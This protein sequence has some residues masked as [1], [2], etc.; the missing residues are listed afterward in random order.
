MR[1]CLK[2]PVT[3]CSNSLFGNYATLQL[4]QAFGQNQLITSS[5]SINRF[6]SVFTFL[7]KITSKISYKLHIIIAYTAKEN[8]FKGNFGREVD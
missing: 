1:V 5:T 3:E 8:V 2:V 4:L 6:F 7:E